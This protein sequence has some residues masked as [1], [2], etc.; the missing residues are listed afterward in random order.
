MLDVAIVPPHLTVLSMRMAVALYVTGISTPEV[1]PEFPPRP[2]TLTAIPA[3]SAYRSNWWVKGCL[4]QAATRRHDPP[5]HRYRSTPLRAAAAAQPVPCGDGGGPPPRKV[6]A[7]RFAG[8][9]RSSAQRSSP[10]AQTS[11]RFTR[12]IVTELLVAR[13]GCRSYDALLDAPGDRGIEV[14]QAC[15]PW[16]VSGGISA[17]S[18][19][20]R[21][22]CIDITERS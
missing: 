7:S 2:G 10:Q 16:A 22:A 12:F 18:A 20:A 15:V 1:H 17:P 9:A 19:S 11:S 4:D 8:C 14:S 3:R 13:S 21:P 5:Q 6:A